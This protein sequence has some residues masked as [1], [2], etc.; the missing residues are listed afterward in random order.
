MPS[1][2]FMW[3][4]HRTTV[5]Q[6]VISTRQSSTGRTLCH[7]QPSPPARFTVTILRASSQK[8]SKIPDAVCNNHIPYTE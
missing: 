1:L 4:A 8:V 7:T 3:V 2:L 6:R 5:S